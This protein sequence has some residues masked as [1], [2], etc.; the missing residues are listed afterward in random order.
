M[1]ILVTG[2]RGH[3]G[4][5]LM[6]RLRGDN[7]AARGLDLLPSPYT[8]HVGSICDRELVR[9]SLK[10]VDVVVHAATLH[11]P[12][13]ATH[14][15]EDFIETNVAGTLVLLEE[16]VAAGART[17]IYTST[18]ST[19]GAALRP[20]RDEP[21]AWITE[22]VRPVPKNIYG[23]TKI[24]AEDLCELFHR[25]YEL[26]VLVLRTS[27]FFPEP[28]DDPDRRGRYDVANT[29]AN[30]LLYRRADIADIVEA[31]LLAMEK[32]RQI[33]FGRYIIS[34]TTPFGERDLVE[35]RRDAPRVVQRLFPEF[36]ALYAAKGWSLFPELDRVYV[37]A[38]A[39]AA[40]GWE[41][42]YNFA[43]VLAC[44]RDG[45]D[46]RSDLARDIGIKGYHGESYRDGLYPVL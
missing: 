13:I 42:R 25:N 3:L 26:P 45:R 31:H 1:T 29:Q 23:V 8:D 34:A 32:A 39:R 6:R 30:E 14:G 27:R 46:F 33:G 21:A 28:D 18:T 7:R 38:K 11:K 36:E 16:A 10:G 15:A 44:L 40:L 12:H 24:A 9:E 22:D 19:F 20:A 43:H 4:E 2:S 17:F 5:A 35:L 41:P 37:N